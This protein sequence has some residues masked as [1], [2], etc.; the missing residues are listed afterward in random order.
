[1]SSSR[2]WTDRALP[3]SAGGTTVALVGD[4]KSGD[5]LRCALSVF[6]DEPFPSSDNKKCPEDPTCTPA[7]MAPLRLDCAAL[8]QF[9][10]HVAFASSC[11][12]QHVMQ[13]W[14]EPASANPGTARLPPIHRSCP[15]YAEMSGA[16]RPTSMNAPTMS[17][18]MCILISRVPEVHVSFRERAFSAPAAASRSSRKNLG[19]LKTLRSE[20]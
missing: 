8:L 11:G 17:G 13:E 1:M 10:H 18:Q 20:K 16:L 12:L 5:A 19:F 3:T 7:L 14:D 9:A 2:A 4:P 6:N 15:H